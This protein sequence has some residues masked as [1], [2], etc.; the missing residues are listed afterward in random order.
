MLL[1]R[2]VVLLAAG[3]LHSSSSSSNPKIWGD[4]HSTPAAGL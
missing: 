1:R 2:S 3:F 4:Q